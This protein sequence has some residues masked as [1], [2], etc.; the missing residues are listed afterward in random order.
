MVV[1]VYPGHQMCPEPKPLLQETTGWSHL[2]GE[3]PHPT[4]APNPLHT[5][6]LGHAP[7]MAIGVAQQSMSA[8]TLLSSA[9]ATLLPAKRS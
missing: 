6:L 8:V 5:P 3:H 4:A 9:A 1:P 7:G 2:W